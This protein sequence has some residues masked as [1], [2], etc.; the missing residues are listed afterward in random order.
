MASRFPFC[1]MSYVAF[2][3]LPIGCSVR[4]LCGYPI[5]RIYNTGM[6]IGG[7]VTRIFKAIEHVALRC[8]ATRHF[9]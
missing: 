7:C 2:V 4:S 9:P 1:S 3:G 5:A 8:T 6:R